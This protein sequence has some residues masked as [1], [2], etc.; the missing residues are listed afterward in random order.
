M[1]Y[2]LLPIALFLFA[3]LPGIGQI[4]TKR[5]I[6]PLALTF[7]AG[8]CDGTA[9]A[10]YYHFDKMD[11]KYGDLNDQFWNGKISHQ[12]K[13]KN[14]DPQQGPAYFGS[15]TFL[16]WTTDSYHLSRMGR[17]L[18]IS[19]AVAIKIGEKQRWWHYPLEAVIYW[20]TYTFG[21]TFAYD[22]VW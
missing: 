14:F 8:M 1:K 3:A 10:S 12:N 11:H 17:N 9:E 16:V 2:L 15:T 20:L 5:D 7:F 21:F 6:A 13:Y 22:W 19:T 4:L 18:S